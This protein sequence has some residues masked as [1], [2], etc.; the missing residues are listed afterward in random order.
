MAK[1]AAHKMPKKMPPRRMPMREHMDSKKK[2]R[3]K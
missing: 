2:R 3:K 1:H